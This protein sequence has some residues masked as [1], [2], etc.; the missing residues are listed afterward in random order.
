MR[1]LATVPISEVGNFFSTVIQLITP[2]AILIL[3]WIYNKRTQEAKESENRRIEMEKTKEDAV[4][5]RIEK[6]EYAVSKLKEDMRNIQHDLEPVAEK[7]ETEADDILKRFDRVLDLTELIL[8]YSSRV[9]SLTIAL[10]TAVMTADNKLPEDMQKL[11]NEELIAVKKQEEE[12][13]TRIYKLGFT[14]GND[15]E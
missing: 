5:E 8:T 7:F 1:I 9:G 14:G 13:K 6:I 12:L 15:H 11:V 3:G 2:F 10:A 4:N